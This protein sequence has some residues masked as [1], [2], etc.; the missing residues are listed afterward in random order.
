MPPA[1]WVVRNP[2][3]EQ[4]FAVN[5]APL[6]AASFKVQSRVIAIGP[7]LVEPLPSAKN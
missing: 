2:A 5:L 6:Y 7:F 1:P 3:V 4:P